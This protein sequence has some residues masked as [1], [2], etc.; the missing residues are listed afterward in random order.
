M[1]SGV[2]MKLH[3]HGLERVWGDTA[4]CCRNHP[5]RLGVGVGALVGY[6]VVEAESEA[7]GLPWKEKY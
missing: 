3:A 1:H 4:H 7:S 2:R 5:S 6:P